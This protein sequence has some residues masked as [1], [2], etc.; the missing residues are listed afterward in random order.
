MSR[1]T[2][3]VLTVFE[4]GDQRRIVGLAEGARLAYQHSV[5]HPA[6]WDTE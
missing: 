6:A 1:E 3:E 2:P 5:Y 4:A